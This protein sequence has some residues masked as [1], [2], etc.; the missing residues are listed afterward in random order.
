[1][2]GDRI[3]RIIFTDQYANI[4]FLVNGL[5]I[6][7]FFAAKKKKRQRAMKFG[8]YETLQKVAGKNFLRSGNILLVTKIMALTALIVALSNPVLVQEK[9]ST[10]ADYVI[11]ISSYSTMLSSDMDPT[12]LGAAKDISEQFIDEVSND[13][14]IGVISFAGDVNRESEMTSNKYEL[15]EAVNEIDISEEAGTAIGDAIY[16]GTSML[17][18]GE[19]TREVILITDSRNSAGSPLNESISYANDHNVSV[20][21]IGIGEEQENGEQYGVVDGVN[22]TRADYPNLDVENLNRTA[23]ETGG[24]FIT[25]TDTEE[26][27]L[28]FLEFEETEVRT[29]LSIYFI[30]LALGSILLEWIL[31]TTRYSILP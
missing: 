4:L 11:A 20:T 31:G 2:V 18:G 30:F 22:A 26:M 24:E 10:N 6:L 15:K 12:R 25:V 21:I 14:R 17:L 7:F 28:A 13:T 27:E 16:T 23:R 3:M 9:T 5:A 19:R 29:D 1:V 8:N